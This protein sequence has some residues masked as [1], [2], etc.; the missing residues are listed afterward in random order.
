MK[1]LTLVLLVLVGSMILTSISSQ[2]YADPQLDSLLRIANQAR[3]NIKIRLSQLATIPDEIAKLYRE[4]SAETDALAQ[5]I[6][7]EDVSSS[8]QHFLSAMKLFRDVSNKMHSLTPIDPPPPPDTTRYKKAIDRMEKDGEM[9]KA[10]ATK[11]NLNIGFTEFDNLIQTARQHLNAGNLE[12]V[13]K[14]LEIAKQFLIHTHN[15]IKDVVKQKPSDRDRSNTANEIPSTPQTSDEA[16]SAKDSKLERI[17][18]KIQTIEEQLNS[19]SEKAS[20]NE[21]AAQWLKRAFSLVEKAKGELD[22]SPDKAMRTL[23]EIDKII[24]MIQRIVQ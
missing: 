9:V 19:L 22:K 5:S 16:I 6:T 23:N 7:K 1:P 10:L 11:Y 15:S 13:T 24:R 12:E 2:V 8:R 17:K 14:T 4:G 18:T 20:E 3:D 21:V